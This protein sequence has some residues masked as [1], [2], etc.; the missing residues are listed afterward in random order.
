[1]IVTLGIL[2]LIH[3][4]ALA[5]KT[6]PDHLGLCEPVFFITNN[7]FTEKGGY[8]VAHSFT[9]LVQSKTLNKNWLLKTQNSFMFFIPDTD[10][11]HSGG[12]IFIGKVMELV[13]KWKEWNQE[14]IQ[15]QG[16]QGIIEAYIE[17]AIDFFMVKASLTLRRLV[18][19]CNRV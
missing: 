19:Q 3:V 8:K 9:Y 12:T 17:H 2:S 18:G 15:F 5:Q 14:F 1:M 7:D 6:S 13:G 16:C 11:F 10:Y 4:N